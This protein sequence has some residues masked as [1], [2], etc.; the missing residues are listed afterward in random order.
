MHDFPIQAVHARVVELRC[1]GANYG[2]IF[3]FRIPKLVVPFVL[4]FDIAHGIECTALVEFVDGNHVC[5][6]EHID[7]FQLRGRAI[8]RGHHVQ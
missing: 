4:L 8:F 6:I 3:V 7:F 1:D 5:K 2:Q